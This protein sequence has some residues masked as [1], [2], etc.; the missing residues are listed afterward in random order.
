MAAEKEELDVEMLKNATIAHYLA[1]VF[2]HNEVAKQVETLGEKLY[3]RAR[4]EQYV[5]ELHKLGQAFEVT[6]PEAVLLTLTA[7]R[8]AINLYP[9][10]I[11]LMRQAIRDYDEQNKKT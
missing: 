6:Q 8:M 3:H 7:G 2:G 11:E 4:S 5:K 10:D 1:L 9:R